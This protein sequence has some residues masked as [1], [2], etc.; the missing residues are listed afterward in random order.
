LKK[1]YLKRW[2]QL[3]QK[4][5]GAWN[6]NSLKSICTEFEKLIYKLSWIPA[7]PYQ[8]QLSKAM[9]YNVN[10]SKRHIPRTAAVAALFMSQTERAYSL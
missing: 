4:V 6:N 7:T 1:G 3:D 8:L 5:V 9:A 10:T 2:N